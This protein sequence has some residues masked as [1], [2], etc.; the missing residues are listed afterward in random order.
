MYLFLVWQMLLPMGFLVNLILLAD[1][2]AMLPLGL[3][4]IF[5]WLVLLAC[6]FIMADGDVVTNRLMF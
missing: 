3:H 5:V 1:V 4:L 2:V 6:C